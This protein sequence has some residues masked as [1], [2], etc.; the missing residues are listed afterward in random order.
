MRQL[1]LLHF[2][3]ALLLLVA[4][5]G[6]RSGESKVVKSTTAGNLNVTLSTPTGQLKHGGD[7]FTL[8]FTDAQGKPAE[9]G[10]VTVTL[11][12]AA[13][14]TMP[15][16]NERTTLKPTGAPGVYQGNVKVDAAGEWEAQVSYEGPAGRGQ[17][18]F[19]I[20]VH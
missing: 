15:A 10:T 20:M 7:E 12:M 6:S 19:P 14:G 13:I 2:F 4:A 9:A 18:S 1:I 11:H 17:T 5:C 8:T 16:M 3:A